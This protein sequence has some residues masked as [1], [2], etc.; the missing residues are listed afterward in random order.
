MMSQIALINVNLCHCNGV[1]GIKHALACPE[2]SA[3]QRK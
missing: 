1:N 2:A 3:V